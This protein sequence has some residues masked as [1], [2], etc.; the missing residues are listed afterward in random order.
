MCGQT[1]KDVVVVADDSLK[2]G[3]FCVSQISGLTHS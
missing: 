2:R 3:E 1:G